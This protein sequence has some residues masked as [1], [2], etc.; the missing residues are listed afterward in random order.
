M[1]QTTSKGIEFDLKGQ[2]VPGLNAVV[3]YAYTDSR[4]SEDTNPANIGLPSPY[5]AK[6]VQNTWLSYALPLKKL[7]GFGLAA[8]YQYQAGRTGRFPQDRAELANFFQLDGGL[9]WSNQR[10]SVNLLINNLLNDRL[11]GAAWG[12]PIGLF[13]YVPLAPRNFRLSVAYR[14]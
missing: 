4:I 5:T 13:T 14:F 12:R 2:I 9:N 10:V 3:N 8:G 1:G 7:P 6:H 11:Y